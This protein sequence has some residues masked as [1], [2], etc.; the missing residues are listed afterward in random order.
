M[1]W[2]LEVGIE[3]VVEAQKRINGKSNFSGNPAQNTGIEHTEIIFR[4]I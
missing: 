2:K 3:C 1:H 4:T